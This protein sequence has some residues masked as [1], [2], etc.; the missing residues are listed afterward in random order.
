MNITFDPLNRD[1]RSVVLAL[2]GNL[3]APLAVSPGPAL[4]SGCVQQTL[5]DVQPEKKTRAKK[6]DAEP[7]AGTVALNPDLAP[8]ADAVLIAKDPPCGI[9]P[10][11]N[12]RAVAPENAPAPVEPSVQT[13]GEMLA[14]TQGTTETAPNRPA[15][16]QLVANPAPAH[17]K[18][19]VRAVLSQ[20]AARGADQAKQAQEIMKTHGKAERLS[21]I[22]ASLYGAVIDAAA[23]AG[24]TLAA[25]RAALAVQQK[26]G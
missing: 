7:S 22:D 23:K 26:A 12:A 16:A 19:D 11:D 9:P 20:L 6:K 13:I 2:L 15:E 10:V 24:M 4:P 18:D 17:T 21:L 3:E 25:A 14:K 1:E 8:K 5:A